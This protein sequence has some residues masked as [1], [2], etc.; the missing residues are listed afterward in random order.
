MELIKILLIEDN[1]GD[2]RL[3]QDMLADAKNVEFSVD[4]EQTLTS[5]IKSL[6]KNKYDAVLLDLGLPDSP[7][8]SVTFTRVQTIAPTLPIIILTGLD[9]DLFAV[10]TVRR[11]AQDYLVKG[12]IESGMLV[13]T[14]RHAI[15][16]KFGGER[17]FTVAELAQYDGKEGRAA[18][19]AFKGKVYDATS[20]HLWK[21][22]IH[23]EMHVAGRDMTEA[24]TRAPHGE[25]VL[26]K[27]PILGNLMKKETIQQ[28]LLQKIDSLHPHA[29]V[30]HLSV[31]S[32]LAAPFTF[33][34]WLFF[35]RTIFDEITLYLLLVGLITVPLSFLTGIIS[36]MV[37]YESKATRVFNF[38]IALGILL[39]LINLATLV[40]RF[41]GY[42]VVLQRPGSYLYL[43][44][45]VIQFT[46]TLIL[47]Y[48]GK[49]IVYS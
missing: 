33:S 41:T 45:L 9:D 5:G 36:W 12:K 30:V 38:K 48:Y 25:E 24:I 16:R 43:T 18:Y 1:P 7:Q 6:G 13:R 44:S 17:L 11:G 10:T 42:E 3:I 2:A 26:G 19:I 21:D 31:A 37:S 34:V 32:A 22:G 35:G 4:W 15:A 20:S 27:L 40:W 29:T 23:R 39:F 28:Q 47:D 46:L 49:D 14:I 8:R